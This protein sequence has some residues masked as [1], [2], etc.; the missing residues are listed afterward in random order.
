MNPTTDE[1]I[2]ARFSVALAGEGAEPPAELMVMPAGTH[3]IHGQR[4]GKHVQM[5]LQVDRDTAATMQAALEAHRADGKQRPFFDFDHEKKAASAWPQ[6]F[7]WREKPAA[8]V[9]A[10]VEWSKAGADAIAGKAYR[11][12]SPAFFP[13]GGNP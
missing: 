1:P 6:R 5:T 8:G 2:L 11:A 4:K 9:Y 3:T 12:F 7:V 10:A 13:D